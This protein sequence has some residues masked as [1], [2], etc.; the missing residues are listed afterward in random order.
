MLLVDTVNAEGCR[1]HWE[2]IS[3]LPPNSSICAGFYKTRIDDIECVERLGL[4][5]EYVARLI[6]Y[7]LKRVFFCQLLQSRDSQ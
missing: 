7:M 3:T 5:D 4:F 6:T 2:T 1:L